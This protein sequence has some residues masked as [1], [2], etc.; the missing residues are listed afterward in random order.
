MAMPLV[1]WRPVHRSLACQRPRNIS[2][3]SGQ[4]LKVNS[5]RPKSS[6]TCLGA[7][8]P[9]LQQ[10]S[11]R[12][13]VV[14]PWKLGATRSFSVLRERQRLEGEFMMEKVCLNEAARVV[15]VEWSGGGVSRFPYVWLRDNCQCQKCFNPDSRARLVLMADLDVKL[16]PVR[17]EVQAA[18]SLLTVDWPDGH[19]SQYDWPWLKARCFS[20]QALEKRGKDWQ[21]KTQLW[22]S[23]LAQDLPK[24]DFSVLLTDDRALYDFLFLLDSV[25]LVLVQ[26]VPCEVGQ[27][28]RLA[29]RVAFLKHT[30]Y[31]K[32]FVVKS[33]PNPSNVAYTSAKLGLHTD[34]PQYN[35]TPGVQMLH[36][37][38]QSKGEGG[39]NHLV[40]GINVAYQLKEENPEAFRLLTT[41]KVNFKDDGLDYHRFDLRE[42]RTILSLDDQGNV[43]SINYNDQVRD[44]I[45][46][47]PAE[48]V[49]PLYDALKAYNTIMYL[50]RNCV[51]HKM[52]AGEMIAFNNTRTLHGRLAY[53]LTGGTRHLQGGY[54]DWDEIYSRM[55]VLK[56]DLGI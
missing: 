39:D 6:I 27:V 43:E 30:N 24:A 18:G 50:P 7:G 10:G 5:I 35:Y 32:E 8:T 2:V 3:L 47:L 54:L 16:S 1:L 51:R 13:E 21:R 42:R 14:F 23:E 26:N 53:S 9:H 17:A 31:G 36:C 28:D 46:D 12:L 37:I 25:G 4:R 38:E 41:L 29:N 55:R 48:Q 15:E 19:Q 20:T 52:A 34:L 56:T 33:K 45:L 44:S 49:Q 22:G 11:R 40:D